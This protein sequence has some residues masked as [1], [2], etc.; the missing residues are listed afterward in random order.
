MLGALLLSSVFNCAHAKELNF[1]TQVQPEL[2]T[3]VSTI[4]ASPQ[5]YVDKPITI[6]GTIVKVC[7]KRG[8]WMNIASDKRFETLR[9]KVKDGVMV[10]PVSAK[11][12]EA[13]ATGTLQALKFN[14]E[15]TREIKAYYAK[16]EGESFD[17][18]SV[19]EPMTMYQ[20]V[21]TGVSILD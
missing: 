4:M 21:P 6:K 13:I 20:L 16:E 3:P 11:G 7:T 1:G 17:P 8:C 2:L 9:I 15:R 18:A 10:F 19:T 12:R 14:L 5:Q